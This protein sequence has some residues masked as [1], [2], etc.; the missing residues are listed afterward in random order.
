MVGLITMISINNKL[1]INKRICSLGRKFLHSLDRLK[2][3]RMIKRNM[4][5]ITLKIWEDFVRNYPEKIQAKIN[6]KEVVIL[7]R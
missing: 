3:Q 4:L 6:L 1:L 5:I 7:I 2:T